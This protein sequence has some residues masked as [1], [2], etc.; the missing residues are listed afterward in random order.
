MNFFLF[1]REIIFK[2]FHEKILKIQISFGLFSPKIT[3]MHGNLNSLTVFKYKI[4][5]FMILCEFLNAKEYQV[6]KLNIDTIRIFKTEYRF[7][8]LAERMFTKLGI[9]T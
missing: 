2:F 5:F 4:T 6:F 1:I 8:S 9:M 3:L 7:F